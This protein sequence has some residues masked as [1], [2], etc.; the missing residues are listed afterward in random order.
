MSHPVEITTPSERELAMTR[1]FDA[2]RR[3]VF[4]ALTSPELIKR[5]LLGPDGW[6]MPVCEFDGKIGSAYRYVWRRDRDGKEMAMGGVI[7]EMAPPGRMV[8][9]ERFEDPW[10]QG[11][12]VVTHTLVEK[13][14]K[15]TYT[16]VMLFESRETR[17]AVLKSGMEKGVVV[18]YERLDRILA[19]NNERP[20]AAARTER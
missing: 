9:T 8:L 12:A 17:D 19:S 4:E 15:T 10:Y 16:A 11:E 2:P 7:R 13:A 5:W 3:L 6:S 14:G 1:L 18:S 20:A